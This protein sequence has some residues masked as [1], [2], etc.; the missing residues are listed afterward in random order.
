MFRKRK[1]SAWFILVAAIVVISALAALMMQEPS[2]A[3]YREESNNEVSAVT[4]SSVL[5]EEMTIYRHKDPDFTVRLP[6]TWIQVVKDGYPT[7]IHRESAS[8]IQI[9]TGK[10]TP[11]LLKITKE[12]IEQEIESIGGELVQFYWADQWDYV[13]MYRTFQKSGTTAHIEVT[14]FNQTDVVR[15]AFAINEIHY[16][17]LERVVASVIDSFAWDRFAEPE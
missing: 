4:E 14:A 17:K 10:S 3:P 2:P 12:S 13:V 16:E 5:E 6:V 9:Q 11:E 15:L 7:W 8:S 1:V